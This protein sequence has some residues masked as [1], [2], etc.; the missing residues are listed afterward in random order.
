M[1]SA[2]RERWHKASHSTCSSVQVTRI[3]HHHQLAYKT[4][5]ASLLAW[6]Q[7]TSWHILNAVHLQPGHYWAAYCIGMM[8]ASVHSYAQLH[9]G[10]DHSVAAEP[11]LTGE[12][13][14]EQTQRCNNCGVTSTPAWRRFGTT[15]LCNACGLRRSRGSRM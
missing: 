8:A 5:A 9:H 11:V 4:S 1:C 12:S 6:A 15:L 2:V 10:H 13:A 3:A 7:P 14:S